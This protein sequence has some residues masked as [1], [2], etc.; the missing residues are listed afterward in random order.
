MSTSI[1]GFESH[2]ERATRFTDPEPHCRE[3]ICAAESTPGLPR[4]QPISRPRRWQLAS[5]S[6][7]GR[8]RR[9]FSSRHETTHMVRLLPA[10]L[11]DVQVQVHLAVWSAHLSARTHRACPRRHVLTNITPP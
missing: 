10:A 7:V 11:C 2:G 1:V 6:S 3:E 9:Q 8:A 4:C 5:D